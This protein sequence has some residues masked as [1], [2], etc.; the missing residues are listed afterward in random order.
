MTI[1]NYVKEVLFGDAA[2]AEPTKPGKQI[3]TS[4]PNADRDQPYEISNSPNPYSRLQSTRIEYI[5]D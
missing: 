5:E 1:L 2:E 4:R 3:H